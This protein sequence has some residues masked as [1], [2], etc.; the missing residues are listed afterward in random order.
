VDPEAVTV[1]LTA[2]SAAQDA[3]FV[4]LADSSSLVEDATLRPSRLIGGQMVALLLAVHGIVMPRETRDAD[5]GFTP[6]V[7]NEPTIVDRL[8]ELG[9]ER[10]AGN[11]FERTLLDV[12]VA[13]G[14]APARAA[15]DVLVPA[16]TDEPGPAP[17]SVIRRTSTRRRS[18]DSRSPSSG[19]PWWWS[20]SSVAETAR[21]S[22]RPWICRTSP[23]H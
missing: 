6:A 1:N 16:Y 9:Y 7:L 23:A 4:A 12:P 14:D 3:A 5:L 21:S 10:S 19:H 8:K 2:T 18:S 11:R 15:I 17:V 20:W 22:T 13:D